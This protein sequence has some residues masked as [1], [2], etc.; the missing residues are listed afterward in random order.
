MGQPVCNM[1]NTTTIAPIT[2]ARFFE[3][4]NAHFTVSSATGERF[5]YRIRR[6]AQDKPFFISVMT[7]PSN[8][9]SYTYL[10]IFDPATATVRTTA[11]SKF[12]F[13]SKEAKVV[14]WAIAMVKASRELPAGYA[15]QHEGKCACCGRRLTVPASIATGFG[16]ECQSRFDA[17]SGAKHGDWLKTANGYCTD[18][19]D[20]RFDGRSPVQLP[21]GETMVPGGPG[22]SVRRDGEGEVIAYEFSL[23]GLTYTI[24][25]D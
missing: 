12:A 23:N 20:I 17:R 3:G 19:S 21:T 13:D 16:P 6:P 5:T 24:Y 22:Y 8:E 9:G 7:G 4:G 15:I 18:A 10:G 2:E 11:N 14:R 1:T 25:N